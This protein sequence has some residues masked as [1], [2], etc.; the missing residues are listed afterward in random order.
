MHATQRRIR[1]GPT[2][3][4][5]RK[6][7]WLLLFIVALGAAA[8]LL[9]ENIGLFRFAAPPASSVS[10]V[11]GAFGWPMSQRSPGRNAF[12]QTDSWAPRREIRWTF[13]T[14][15]SISGSPAVVDGTVY[16]PT[17]NLPTWDGRLVSLDAATGALRWEFAASVPVRSSP[18]VAG[19]LVYVGLEDGHVVALDKETGEPRWRFETGNQVL[20]SPV[21]HEGVLFVGSND[22][23]LYALDATTGERRWSFKAGNVIRSDPAVHPPVLAF[24]DVRGRLYILGIG[25]A[26]KR[27][28]HMT[29]GNAQGGGGPVFQGDRLYI[30]DGGGIVR[31]VDWTERAIPF[32]KLFV[33]ARIQL[34]AWGLIDSPGQQRGSVWFFQEK[35]GWF[36]TAPVVAWGK[37]YAASLSGSLFALD[38]GT[39]AKVWEFKA[40][41]AFEASPLVVGETVVAGDAGGKLY[42]I[43]AFTGE[44]AWDLAFDS[45][46]T[47]G[48]VFAD[49][50]LYVGTENGTLYALE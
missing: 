28:D 20:S 41:D 36:I 13:Q 1:W 22:R 16:L 33:R 46:I 15:A 38:Q 35:G 19:R 31:A 7:R 18:A 44:L 45:G 43:N 34:W 14:K 11:S 48:P 21:V 10:S 17:A 49:G 50:M 24:T 3:G 9:H 27:F 32:E 47:S 12:V 29:A 40:D 23:H 4:R 2:S 6:R 25:T 26:R 42:A 5:R 8:W 37:V 39:G 30:A